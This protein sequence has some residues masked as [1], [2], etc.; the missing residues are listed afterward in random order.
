[1][2]A[3]RR[4]GTVGLADETDHQVEM[5]DGFAQAGQDVGTLLRAG[6]VVRVRRVTISRRNFTNAWSICFRLTI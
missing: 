3:A 5:L 4:V 6:E 1:M 2:R